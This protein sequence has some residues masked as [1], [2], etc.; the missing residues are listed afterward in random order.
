MAAAAIVASTVFGAVQANQTRQQEK[1]RLGQFNN[2]YE[3]LGP[4]VRAMYD[5][6]LR[7]ID[8]GYTGAMNQASGIG[9]T[10]KFNASTA[11]QRGVASQTDSA[12]GRGLYGTSLVG[13]IQRGAS[14]D[15]SRTKA[16]I[17]EQTAALLSGLMVGKAGAQAS[18]FGQEAGQ[19]SALGMGQAGGL[20][21]Q[22]FRTGS[23]PS[24]SDMTSL[25]SMF[26]GKGGGG[27]G[28]ENIVGLN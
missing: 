8:T 23:S 13:S 15:L 12:I 22:Q 5:K 19:L 16:G 3:S 27:G 18:L 20:M 21:S 7:A 1:G 4:E 11:S 10:A 24:A 9:T 28:V 26:G 6:A 17:D 2:I 25:F 14:A